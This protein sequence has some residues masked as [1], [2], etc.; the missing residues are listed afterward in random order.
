MIRQPSSMGVGHYAQPLGMPPKQEYVQSPPGGQMMMMPGGSSFALNRIQ[1]DQQIPSS[2]GYL[3]HG[4][5]QVRVFNY[6]LYF[7]V[8][9][10]F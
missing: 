2:I 6:Y 4:I 8:L 3:Q 7:F 10:C 1:Q 9:R 5:E